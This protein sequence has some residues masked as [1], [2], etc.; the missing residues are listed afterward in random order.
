MKQPVYLTA[1]PGRRHTMCY[2]RTFPTQTMCA[3]RR[4]HTA[5]VQPVASQCPTALTLIGW[6][7]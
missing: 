2:R 5:A 3:G 4:V 1:Q 6:P 7:S